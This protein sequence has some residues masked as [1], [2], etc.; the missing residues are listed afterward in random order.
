MF[1]IDCVVVEGNE[2]RIVS[3]RRDSGTARQ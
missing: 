2:E 1:L 3:L